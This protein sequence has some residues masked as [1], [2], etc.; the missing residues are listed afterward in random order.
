MRHGPCPARSA[1]ARI[2]ARAHAHAQPTRACV[3]AGAMLSAGADESDARPDGSTCPALAGR[4][5]AG[6]GSA[7][8]WMAW[9]RRRPF[10]IGAVARPGPDYGRSAAA[11][12]GL[13]A[14]AAAP[15]ACQSESAAA[16]ERSLGGASAARAARSASTLGS[17]PPPQL[18][19]VAIGRAAAA[20]AP[21]RRRRFAAYATVR[22]DGAAAAAAGAAWARWRPRLMP[23]RRQARRSSG[24]DMPRAA[25]AADS[26]RQCSRARI[27]SRLNSGISGWTA[28]PPR[29]FWSVDWLSDKGNSQAGS[30]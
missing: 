7:A 2:R 18:P 14:A 5:S 24:G 22:R 1:L 26:G 17:S 23:T 25:A 13:A 4:A 27:V 16:T 9:A 15:A 29:P 8:L 30:I 3:R 28:G 11:K 10:D 20:P 12:L 21:Y 6:L 19:S